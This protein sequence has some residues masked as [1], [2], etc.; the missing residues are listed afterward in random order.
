MVTRINESRLKK[1]LVDIDFIY[2]GDTVPLASQ[3]A[4]KGGTEPPIGQGVEEGVEAGVEPEQQA[5]GLEEI[6]ADARLTDGQHDGDDG[7]RHPAGEVGGCEETQRED[8]LLVLLQLLLLLNPDIGTASAAAVGL[9][10]GVGDTGRGAPGGGGCHPPGLGAVP[11]VEVDQRVEGRDQRERNGEIDEAGSCDK[12][13]AVLE[14]HAALER[15]INRVAAHDIPQE[16]RGR[17]EEQREDPAYGD[18]LQGL[19]LG[20][21]HVVRGT[22]RDYEVPIPGDHDKSSGGAGTDCVVN[23]EPHLAE[24]R[25]EDPLIPLKEI[26]AIE[27]HRDQPYQEVGYGKITYIAIMRGAQLF[28]HNEGAKG[29]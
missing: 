27:R 28:I 5:D 14:L 18:L 10:L 6:L 12:N 8:Q 21:L 13:R 2:R 22:L 17:V 23:Y 1:L 16:D 11:Q 26:R 7:E 15:V 29:Q 4:A 3:G 19:R 25:S 24:K 20:L 9:R